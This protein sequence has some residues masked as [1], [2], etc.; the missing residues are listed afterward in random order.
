MNFLLA[1]YFGLL[2][3]SFALPLF[4]GIDLP[5][6]RLGAALLVLWWLAISLIRNKLYIC[7]SAPGF[8]LTGFLLLATL[9]SFWADNLSWATR[10]ILFLWTFLPLF[11]VFVAVLREK[12]SEK[13]VRGAVWGGA[14]AALVGLGQFFLQFLLGV[15]RLFRLWLTDVLPFFLGGNFGEVVAAYPSL[16]VNVQ[17]TTLMRAAAFFPDPHIF[18]FYVGMLAPLSLAL[19]LAETGPKR[20]LFFA[21]CGVL[22]AADFL[23]FSRGGYV[24]LIL[25]GLWFTLLFF[26]K[27]PFAPRKALIAFCVFILVALGLFFSPVSH[28]FVSSFSSSDSS[29]TERLRLWQEALHHIAEKPFLGTGLGNYPLLV[30]PNAALREPIYAHNLLLDIAVEVGLVGLFLFIGFLGTVL[31]RLGKKWRCEKNIMALGIMTS[32]VVFLGHAFFETP[33]FSVHIL[34]LFLFI[35]ALGVTLSEFSKKNEL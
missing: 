7:L 5:V 14:A 32:L 11:F 29:S 1:L 26:K 6:A 24:G 12:K 19:G 17:G 34:P 9:S 15:E 18:A 8:F 33:I 13:I 16:L 10:K 23:S 20:K 25:G 28:R 3:F 4:P 2:P 22:L 27:W 30:K 21:A 35:A 31:W